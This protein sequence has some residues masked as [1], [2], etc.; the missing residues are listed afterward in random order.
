MPAIRALI[1]ALSLCVIASAVVVRVTR[2]S[3]AWQA[4]GK[5][6]VPEET[7]LLAARE[8]LHAK[9]ADRVS[10]AKNRKELRE[11]AQKVLD[12]AFSIRD[13]AA[14]RYAA[15]LEARDLAV[16]GGDCKLGLDI[17]EK[18]HA[19]YTPVDR[20]ACRRDVV[21][22]IARDPRLQPGEIP[23]VATN[24]MQLLEACLKREEAQPS[25]ELW[26]A[27]RI[28]IRKLRDA[29][30]EQRHASA[31]DELAYVNALAKLVTDPGDGEAHFVVGW[32]LAFAKERLLEGIEH[33]ARASDEHEASRRCA[34]LDLENPKEAAA[35]VAVA[36][37]WV[38][39][40][41]TQ[42]AGPRDVAVRRA[43]T[44][45]L[46]AHRQLA[47]PE[48]GAVAE[49]LRRAVAQSAASTGARAAPAK[50]DLVATKLGDSI[51]RALDWLARHQ[52]PDG[53]WSADGF[54]KQC[55]K[56]A[57][58]GPGNELFDTGL[59]GLA[60]LC[61]LRAGETP[62]SSAFG[63]VVKKGLEYLKG[64][65]RPDDGCFG[66]RL[67]M[68][69]VYC[70]ASATIAMAEAHGLTR[71]AAFAES[72]QKAVGLVLRAQNPYAAWRYSYLPDG[73]NDAS[74]TGWMVTSLSSARSA[75]LKIGDGAALSN[76]LGFIEE[77]TDPTTGRVGYTSLG[78]FPSRTPAMV[79]VFPPEMSESLTAV[80]LVV[81][82]HAG[83][84][85]D[86]DD[87]DA[88]LA[89]GADLL[90]R[91]LPSW[92]ESGSIDF[93]YWYYGT[94]AMHHVGGPRRDRWNEAL[95]EALLDHQRMN[96]AE[97]PYGSWDPVDPWAQEGGR[98]YATAL[99]CLSLETCFRQLLTGR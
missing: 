14:A 31:E 36:D 9:F 81:R 41:K 57:C 71:A 32:R 69:W 44:W 80:G 58:A 4:E 25:A 26:E 15:L 21:L 23:D 40:S 88:M 70:H 42:E 94:L 39:W 68:H 60:L 7:A 46:L 50:V 27:L 95:R 84:R 2:S 59:T 34:R 64:I 99:N 52:S 79:S 35:R 74:V 65:Q 12:L 51:E 73:D 47:G 56:N 8:T 22:G 67:G 96:E 11:L 45:Y 24:G 28:P 5:T 49:K 98:V 13:D 93:Y 76:A 72:A 62:D 66:Q 75:G 97:D 18:M 89:K 20:E 53:R 19:G 90:T 85:L 87:G 6:P 17:V 82:A 37:A 48:R 33:L 38:A 3:P 63:G 29:Q 91:R 1:V 16:K 86:G 78:Q 92:D 83:R 10:K 43:E 77:I 54:S 61:F 55:R 30:L